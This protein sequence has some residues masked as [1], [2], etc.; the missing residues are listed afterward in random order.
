V[1]DSAYSR[2]GGGRDE[3]DR[4]LKLAD[5]DWFNN[6]TIGG[7]G[8]G[9]A[10]IDQ[11]R[12]SFQQQRFD[13]K[14]NIFK[15]V[16]VP[17][18]NDK[19]LCVREGELAS[20]FLLASKAESRADVILRDGWDSKPLKNIVKGKSQQGISNSLSCQD[21]HMSISGDT[22]AHE[23][24]AK[25][26]EGADENGF[27]NRFVYCYVYR[28]QLCPLG[29]PEIDWGQEIVKLQE[30]ILFARSQRCIGLTA[31]AK[32]TWLRMYIQL[33]NNHL[34]GMAGKMTS[35]A[36]AHIR[37][38]ALIYALIDMAPA[39][40]TVHLRAAER[41]WIYCEDSAQFIFNKTTKGQLE[42]LRWFEK[43]ESATAA[44]VREELFSRNKKASWIKAE[45]DELSRIGRLQLTDGT[46][47]I[48]K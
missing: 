17:G 25:M 4:L 36:A 13:A 14:T 39:V 24:V 42:I 31:S 5:Y 44:I 33:E 23:L 35:R 32:T 9:E 30:I 34:P 22:T 8:S 45:L 21:P 2:K 10:V 29:G 15:V 7:F 46:Y 38:L 26:P 40:D 37:R 3:I 12:D 16:T 18:V 20:V 41:L 48:K 47:K 28:T 27:G 1:G 19:R 11:V 6:C 43:R